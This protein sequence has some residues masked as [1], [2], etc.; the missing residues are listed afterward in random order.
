MKSIIQ[1]E[2]ECWVCGTTLNLHNHHIFYGPNKPNSE[3]LG[4]K[5]YLCA[6]HH[7]MSNGG[8]HFDPEL[9]DKIKIMAQKKFEET[10]TREEFM[11]IMGR[12]YIL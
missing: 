10:H 7:N 4:L 6:R 12:N 2:K 8:V 5:I 1:T 9:D 3:R 11:A